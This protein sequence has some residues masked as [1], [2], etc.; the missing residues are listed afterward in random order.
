MKEIWKVIPGFESYA[1]SSKGRIKRILP[2]PHTRPG[3]ILKQSTW[4]VRKVRKLYAGGMA[5]AAISRHFV[6]SPGLIWSIC[7]NVTY[8]NVK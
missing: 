2:G 5:Q 8:Q 6:E 7:H 4:K 1:A 3:F